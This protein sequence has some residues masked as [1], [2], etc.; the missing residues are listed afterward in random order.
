MGL[1]ARRVAV[2]ATLAVVGTAC[3]S[4]EWPI[5]EDE[6]SSGEEPNPGEPDPVVAQLVVFEPQSP[7]IHG[8]GTAVPLAAELRDVLGLPLDPELVDG[9][10][11]WN[12]DAGGPTLLV[13]DEGEV[14]LEP[15]VHQISATARL[16]DG[17]RLVASVGG[18]YVQSYW[19]GTYEGT[20]DLA[21]AVM[22]QG[23]PLTPHCTGPIA[24]RVDYDGESI[25]FTGGSCSLNAVITTFDVAYTIEGSFSNG[26]GH[27]TIEYD[28]AGFI[29]LSF[30]WQGA[31]IEDAFRG[32][33]E[34]TVSIPLVGDAA[35]SGSFVAPL[36][37]R[38]L[39][40]AP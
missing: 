13:G 21:I 36:Q 33:F 9:G 28:L 35:G 11:V 38:F 2:V 15:G 27:G 34:G 7:S 5:E 17:S 22:F 4:D 12:T 14:E 29:T 26:A 31:F 24:L 32:S 25:E 37:S 19:T 18:V 10:I 8:L 3:T 6:S 23:I 40:D 30:D 39:E 16:A 1:A 20:A